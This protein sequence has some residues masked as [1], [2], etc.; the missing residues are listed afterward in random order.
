[1]PCRRAASQ[2]SRMWSRWVLCGAKALGKLVDPGPHIKGNT[3][4]KLAACNCDMTASQSV[5]SLGWIQAPRNSQGREANR[6]A[7]ALC[8]LP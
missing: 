3:A 6:A 1:M 8:A 5:E 4:L 2:H 7:A